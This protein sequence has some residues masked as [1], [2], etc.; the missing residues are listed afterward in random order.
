M[1]PWYIFGILF[2]LAIAIYIV[3][4]VYLVPQQ[5]AYVVERL[6]KYSATL[7]AGLHLLT[8]IISRV[9]YKHTLKEQ[10]IDEIGR[11]SCRERV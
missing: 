2:S 3:K 6:G 9:A 11:A 5:F 1:N 7:N 10:A 4:Y 8:P